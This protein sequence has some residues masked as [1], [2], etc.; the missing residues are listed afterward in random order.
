ME[1]EPHVVVRGFDIK[2]WTSRKEFMGE[3]KCALEYTVAEKSVPKLDR[4][5]FEILDKNG[6]SGRDYRAKV[7]SLVFGPVAPTQF[8]LPG[9]GFDA[10]M[11]K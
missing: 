9:S 10:D 5:H 6:K 3:M 4:V 2:F 7:Q 1:I 8:T 11:P